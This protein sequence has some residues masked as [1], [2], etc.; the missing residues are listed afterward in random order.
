M[1]AFFVIMVFFFVPNDSKEVL[2]REPI[3]WFGAFLISAGL[4]AICFA[5][6]DAETSPHG[7]ATSYIIAAL[8]LGTVACGLFVWLQYRLKYPLMPP[9]IWR[10]PQF[11][12]VIATY[13]LGFTAF[14]GVLV[15]SYTLMW[16]LVFGK[17]AIG[18][19][20]L[21]SVRP[22]NLVGRNMEYP[23]MAYRA[24]NE[25]CGVIYPSSNLW[26]HPPYRCA[27][28]HPRRGNP[29]SLKQTDNHLLGD[30]IPIS[31]VNDHRCR[32]LLPSLFPLRSRISPEKASLRRGRSLHLPHVPRLRSRCRSQ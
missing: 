14:S 24:A 5:L 16:Q 15:F 6:T 9:S 4:C 20:L 30:D 1:T 2:R 8:V 11:P 31:P 21:T 3:D 28:M 27:I 19:C 29:P 13:F 32:I 23:V 12:R 18:V 22:L 17:N 10:Y 25:F 7:W 26:H